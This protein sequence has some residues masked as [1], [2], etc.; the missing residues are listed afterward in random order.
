[1]DWNQQDDQ[2]IEPTRLPGTSLKTQGQHLYR[3]GVTLPHGRAM[4]PPT[5]QRRGGGGRGLAAPAHVWMSAERRCMQRHSAPRP[6][7][8]GAVS[9][10]YA[11]TYDE[12]TDAEGRRHI[13]SMQSLKKT[14]VSPAVE[15]YFFCFFL[16]IFIEGENVQEKKSFLSCCRRRNR[17]MHAP[18]RKFCR[19][20]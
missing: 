5:R 17:L 16:H 13:G 14:S 12:P 20:L 8:P 4:C 1:M 11:Q 19:E 15:R 6:L 9:L 7:V 2:A 18:R 10:S 3:C